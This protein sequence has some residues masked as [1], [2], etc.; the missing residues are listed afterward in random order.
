MSTRPP[1]L[2]FT[3]NITTSFDNSYTPGSGV[4]ARSISVRRALKRRAAKT[5]NT[6]RPCCPEIQNNPA[7]LAHPKE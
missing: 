2:I 7:D 6:N 3:G 1:S 4:G 5:D